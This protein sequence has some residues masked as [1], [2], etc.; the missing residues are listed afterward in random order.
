M[1]QR[2]HTA[3]LSIVV[4]IVVSYVVMV[5]TNENKV[6]KTGAAITYPECGNGICEENENKINCPQ[7]CGC[8][9][10]CENFDYTGPSQY[11]QGYSVTTKYC[12][13]QTA[14]W[15]SKKNSCVLKDTIKTESSI[16]DKSANY[17]AECYK[18]KCQAMVE[19]INC[20]TPGCEV[21]PVEWN[22]NGTVTLRSGGCRYPSEK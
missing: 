19:T 11:I 20:G 2:L 9:T 4:I 3:L 8:L 6:V 21:I 17:V 16:C 5:S 13:D 1:D 22:K 7:D 15:D 14:V 12:K 10:Y 18:G